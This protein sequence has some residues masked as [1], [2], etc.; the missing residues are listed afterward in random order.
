MGDKEEGYSR[1]TWVAQ[2]AEGLTLD[3]DSGHDLTVWPWGSAL[4]AYCCLLGI[5]SPSLFAPPPIALYIS[6]KINKNTLKKKRGIL[7]R[8]ISQLKARTREDF[9]RA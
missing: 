7:G 4:T 8:W 1:G 2:S 3:F 5:L 9:D 6:I